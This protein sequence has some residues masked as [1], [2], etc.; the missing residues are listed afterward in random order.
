M[1]IA[2]LEK[3]D[4]RQHLLDVAEKLFA[5]NGYEAVSIRQLASES[6]MNVAMVSYY[7]GSKEK[8]FEALLEH[9][10]PKTRAQL[11]S[12]AK[13][14]LSPWE[15][16]SQTVELYV[17]KFFEGRDFHRIV[18]R[19]MSLRQ[20]PEHVKLIIYHMGRNMEVVRGFIV[21]GQEKGIFRYVDLE[22]TLTTLFA[23]ISTAISNTGL[24]C[25]MMKAE[26]EEQL[27]SEQ[28][29]E[30]ITSHVKSV[31]QAHL[32]LPGASPV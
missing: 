16:L 28:N 23:T 4:R 6:G 3:Q 31:L 10:L 25:M 12:L 11:E 14:D 9:K 22:L 13:T 2:V 30:R 29:K 17:N 1:S 5:K 7:F 32:L 8:L 20:R 18:T 21:E 24:M 15:K 27:Y 26:N 19:E